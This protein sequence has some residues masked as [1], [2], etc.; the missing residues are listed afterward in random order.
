MLPEYVAKRQRI[1]EDVHSGYQHIVIAEDPRFGRLLYLDDDLQIAESDEVYNQAMIEPLVDTDN[2][3]EV[4]I[5]GGGDGGVLKA[6]VQHGSEHAVM[7]DIDAQVVDL[8]RTY[9]PKMC[10]DAFA[11]D[12]GELVIGDAFAYL[13][14]DQRYD[15]IVYDLTM[16]P[17]RADQTRKEFIHEI[18][19]KVAS[20]LKPEGVFSMQCCGAEEHTL[21]R[22]IRNGLETYFA[23]SEQ[24]IVDVPSYLPE[25]WVFASA[26]GPRS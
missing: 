16:Q 9:L 1:L 10:E 3:G 24:R 4:L 23:Q 19:D 20:R 5:L 13:D 26:T 8:C 15:A 6:A 11:A 2:L 21:R 12:N 7:V 25:R 22:E 17:V 14:R 18:L